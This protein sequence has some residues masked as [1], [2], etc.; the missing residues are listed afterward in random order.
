MNEFNRWF[1]RMSGEQRWNFSSAA[2]LYFDG[3]LAE[4][5]RNP[6]LQA[7]FD[8]QYEMSI[9][10]SNYVGP[11]EC[12]SCH[13]QV[14]SASITGKDGSFS[15]YCSACDFWTEHLAAIAHG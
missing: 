9:I 11:Y 15:T 1:W 7:R 2:N 4:V 10:E 5:K 6:R 3:L 14:V 12:A 8:F 13:G